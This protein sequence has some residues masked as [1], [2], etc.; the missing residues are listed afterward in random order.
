MWTS[1]LLL[2]KYTYAE[3]KK[4]Q[5]NLPHSEKHSTYNLRAYIRMHFENKSTY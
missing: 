2:S 5:K 1:I 3:N 4:T